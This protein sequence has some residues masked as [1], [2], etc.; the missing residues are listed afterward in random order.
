MAASEAG[1]WR[2][3]GRR[4]IVTNTSN[5]GSAR[6]RSSLIYR[7]RLSRRS[8]ARR[9]RTGPRPLEARWDVLEFLARVVDPIPEPSQQTV[10]YWGFYANAARGKRRKDA[11]TE[12]SETVGRFSLSSWTPTPPELSAAASSS[13]PKSPSPWSTHLPKRWSSSQSPPEPAVPGPA[14]RPGGRCVCWGLH[15]VDD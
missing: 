5:N 3:G 1:S 11:T 12:R 7:G 8:E 6:R 10:R 9:G 2:R 13:R 4:S 14:A 15:L